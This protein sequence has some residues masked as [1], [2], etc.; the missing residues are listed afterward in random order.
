MKIEELTNQVGEWPR[1]SNCKSRDLVATIETYKCLS[2]YNTGSGYEIAKK[3]VGKFA[4]N[5]T[6]V[7]EGSSLGHVQLGPFP[8]EVVS[9]DFGDILFSRNE[10]LKR[11]R[12]WL[13]Y[14]F[15][16]ASHYKKHQNFWT[17]AIVW[18]KLTDE[19]E[20]MDLQSSSKAF[21]EAL[22][23]NTYDAECVVI[24]FLSDSDRADYMGKK[25]KGDKFLVANIHH[26]G[27]P[28]ICVSLNTVRIRREENTFEKCFPEFQK[29]IMY[30]LIYQPIDWKIASPVYG[31]EQLRYVTGFNIKDTT[32]VTFSVKENLDTGAFS[33][34]ASIRAPGDPK[35]VSMKD[36]PASSIE[37]AIEIIK[38]KFLSVKLHF[39]NQSELESDFQYE[40]EVDT[41][42]SHFSAVSK[43]Q[44]LEV[45]KNEWV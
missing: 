26:V 27:H 28:S 40:I 12:R 33:A 39:E 23:A 16:A 38:Q 6:I 5:K 13:R 42:D 25:V 4:I 1:C 22:K 11:E 8:Q 35:P 41:A 9:H 15:K 17:T 24:L 36:Y 3:E 20:V 19:P 32:S 30:D 31:Q 34:F 29:V 21:V 18:K 45:W 44:Q 7:S 43:L 14:W 10:E 37:E 2:C